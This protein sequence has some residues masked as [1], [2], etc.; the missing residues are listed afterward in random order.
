MPTPQATPNDAAFPWKRPCENLTIHNGWFNQA[1]GTRHEQ[2]VAGYAAVMETVFAS[3]EPIDLTENHIRKLHL[4][5]LRT[6]VTG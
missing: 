1:F 5:L 6:P 4:D 2:E 3:Y